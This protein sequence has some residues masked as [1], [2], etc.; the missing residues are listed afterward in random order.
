M[1]FEKVMELF[2]LKYPGKFDD[3]RYL[4]DLK[5][6]ERI[7]KLKAVEL[8]QECFGNGQLRQML[9]NKETE[10]LAEAGQKVIQAQDLTFLQENL[11][12]K[13]V[14]KIPEETL[15]YFEALALVLE[16]GE[17]RAETMAPYFETMK[18]VSVAGF[19]KWPNATI[20]PF[21]AQP[22]RHIFLKPQV[23]KNF[24]VML[25]YDLKYDTTPNWATY[26]ALLTIARD[27]QEKLAGWAPKDLIDI[28]SFIWVVDALLKNASGDR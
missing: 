20:F 3:P 9:Q 2:V 10:K 4:G 27:C 11:R 13:D 21:L 17:V 16:D 28:Q 18:A 26:E 5:S 23:T 7:Y 25:G 6:G 15:K 22:A 19:A 24:A 12:F 1:S 14:L 8:F